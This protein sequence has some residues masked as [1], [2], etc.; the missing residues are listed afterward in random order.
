MATR[1]ILQFDPASQ[2]LLAEHTDLKAAGTA[3]GKPDGDTN[4]LLCCGAN[5]IA[6]TNLRK[7]Y[8]FYWRFAD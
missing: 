2:K 3:I 8:G 6:S 5:H 1:K 7:A 4:I